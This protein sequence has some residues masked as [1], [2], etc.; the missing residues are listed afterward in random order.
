MK[1]RSVAGL[2]FALW[3]AGASAASQVN[4]DFEWAVQKSFVS[5]SL[6]GVWEADCNVAADTGLGFSV[7]YEF[8]SGAQA[9]LITNEYGDT[10]C[11]LLMESRR[12]EGTVSLPQL[13]VDEYGRYVYSVSIISESG[14]IHQ[15]SFAM[16]SDALIIFPNDG[17]TPEVILA[18]QEQGVVR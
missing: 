10:A 16:T 1:C 15:L 2:L 9:S 11:A 8:T 13:T 5:S 3:A 17:A 4:Q 7:S 6:A 18:R 14:E 12:I